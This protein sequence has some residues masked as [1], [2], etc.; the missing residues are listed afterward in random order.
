MSATAA[1]AASPRRRRP[2]RPAPRLPP[3]ASAP[4]A[5]SGSISPG[6]TVGILPAGTPEPGAAVG[7]VTGM[8][9]R[10]PTAVV[11]AGPGSIGGSDGN[12][13]VIGAGSQPDAGR[14]LLSSARS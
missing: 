3:G 14:T 5:A 7:L 8:G 4:A 11:A 2:G 6:V 13:S 12:A 1:P 9:G 10:S